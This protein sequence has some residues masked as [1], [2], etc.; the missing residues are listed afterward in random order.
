VPGSISLDGQLTAT[1][2]C[3]G[4]FPVGITNIQLGVNPCTGKPY[5]NSTGDMQ[6]TV[7]AVAYEQLQGIG[8]G[9]VAAAN[10]LYLRS[11]TN[12]QVRLTLADA[13]Q[14]VLFVNG[15]LFYEAQAGKEVTKVEVIGSGTL[16]YFAAGAS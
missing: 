9:G 5:T 2:Q 4:S 16:E 8:A 11:V 10:T 14:P 6:V 15:T 13:S 12:M 1:P 7:N 3:A